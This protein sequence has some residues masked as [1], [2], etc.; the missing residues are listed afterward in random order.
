MYTERSISCSGYTVRGNANSV[1]GVCE[2][3]EESL[4][5]LLNGQIIHSTDNQRNM[6]EKSVQ[7]YYYLLEKSKPKFTKNKN[8]LTTRTNM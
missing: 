8:Q 7:I 5:N 4:F 6:R 1:E 3:S 2:F